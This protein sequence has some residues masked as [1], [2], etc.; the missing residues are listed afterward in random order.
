MT[1]PRESRKGLD[2]NPTGAKRVLSQKKPEGKGGQKS[3]WAGRLEG[4]T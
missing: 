3:K 2:W 1:G 4:R